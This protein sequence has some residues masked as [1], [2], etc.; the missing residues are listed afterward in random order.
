M[1]LHGVTITLF[2]LTGWA[3]GSGPTIA[4]PVCNVAAF[5]GD[6]EATIGACTTALGQSGLSDAERADLLK[7]RARSLHSTGHLDEA[8][9]D[10]DAALL[11]A[12]N[13]PELH[14]RRGWTAFDKRDFALVFDQ[15]NS[16]IKLKPDYAAAYDLVGATLARRD[17]GRQHEAIAVFREAIRLNPEEPL[18]HLH[19]MEVYTCCGLPEKALEEAEA[20]LHLPAALITKPSSVEYYLKKTS[21]RVDA[22]LER[23]K[24]LS[25][26]GRN[27]EAKQAY[28]QAVS[29][30]PG[31][32]TYAGRAAFLLEYMHSASDE[33][34]ADLDKSFAA[35]PDVWFSHGV[36]GRVLFYRK[37]YS[38]A[39][40][41]FG[42]SLSIYPVNGFIHW[43]RA[44][45]LRALG[46]SDDAA[47]EAVTAF[48]VDPGF[49]FSKA[50]T[51]EKFDFLPSLSGDTDPRPAFYDAARACM[52]DE[53]CW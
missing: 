12:P 37:D 49:M 41:E 27:D 51:L 8:I 52:L 20:V 31:A 47:A 45:T 46:R 17:V 11:L 13:D 26:L 30:D 28:D 6:P 10:Y 23:G 24:L 44:M 50:S 43:W 25:I 16:A 3:I 48:Q 21:F 15:A 2:L 18:F 40:K 42:R 5:E 53:K 29:E 34:Q 1:W 39:E 19:L 7:I 35:D 14:L 22:S 32:L 36:E 4:A 9:K 33:V 38:A